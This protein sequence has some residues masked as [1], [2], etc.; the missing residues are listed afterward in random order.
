MNGF[1][2]VLVVDNGERN[3]DSALSMDLAGMGFASV[4]ASFEAADD[5]LAILPNPSAVVLQ[6]PRNASWTERQRFQALADRLRT[7]LEATGIPVILTGADGGSQASLLQ[8][9][10]GTRVLSKPEL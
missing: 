8:S 10:L 9:E 7:N 2:K 3:P 1:Q 4:T 6:M 5:V